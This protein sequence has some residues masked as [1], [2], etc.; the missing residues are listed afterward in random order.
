MRHDTKLKTAG[1]DAPRDSALLR[2][3]AQ[4][5]WCLFRTVLL[6]ALSFVI[7]Y[8]LLYMVS[9]AIREPNDVYDPTIV[10]VPRH[11]T[12]ENFKNAAEAMEY[13]RALMNTL[14]ISLVSSGIQMAVCSF[15]AYGFARFRFPLKRVFL[16]ALFLMVVIPSQTISMPTFTLYRS[17]AILDTPAVFYLPALFGVGLRSGIFILIFMQFFRNLPK[18]LEDAAYID[19]C[20]FFRTYARIMLPNLRNAML[21][22][23]L[24]SFVWYCSDYYL[25][26]IFASGMPTLSTMLANM[27]QNLNKTMGTTWDTYQIITMQQAGALLTVAPLLIVYLALQ[28][29][30]A[31]SVERSGI[32]G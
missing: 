29:F 17:M 14:L 21:I 4:L 20:G 26:T 2:Y 7:L 28:R 11:F 5:A 10:W 1:Q 3:L 13:P 27:R 12:L 6:I 16:M 30:F 25:T 19:G 31:E 22:V 8:P 23:F 15:I 32:V 24:F 18:D 9:M